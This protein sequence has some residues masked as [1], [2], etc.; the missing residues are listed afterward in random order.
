[1]PTDTISGL[2]AR[3]M[4]FVRQRTD[5]RFATCYFYF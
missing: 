2:R 4:I 1:M 3:G 5:G